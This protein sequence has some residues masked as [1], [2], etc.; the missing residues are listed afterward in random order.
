[1][2]E[3]SPP[4]DAT[5][6]TKSSVRSVVARAAAHLGKTDFPMGER[7]ALRRLDPEH[8]GGR[9]AA[10]CRL[11]ALC[12]W[13]VGGTPTDILSRW[14]LILH[15]LALMSAPGRDPHDPRASAGGAIAESGLSE[16]RFTRLLTARG[17]AFRDHVPRI[18]RF[19]AAKGQRLDCRPLAELVF[20]HDRN[21]QKAEEIRLRL[22]T[23]YYAALSRKGAAAEDR[24]TNA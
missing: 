11:L 14:A 5:A 17:L 8:P 15:A 2:S 1:M 24:E 4:I 10:V 13:D 23:Q 19:L 7:A 21:E 18:A 20:A 3:L 6:A 16:A 22:A 9:I 12:G